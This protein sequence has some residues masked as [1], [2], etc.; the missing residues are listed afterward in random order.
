MVAAVV[1][2]TLNSAQSNKIMRDMGTDDE[3][4]N[5]STIKKRIFDHDSS[6]DFHFEKMTGKEQCIE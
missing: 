1:N 4:C 5:F 3:N 2:D 6:T